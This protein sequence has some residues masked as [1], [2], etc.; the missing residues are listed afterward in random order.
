ME[1]VYHGKV[2]EIERRK[3]SHDTAMSFAAGGTGS[4]SGIDKSRPQAGSVIYDDEPRFPHEVF[5]HPERKEI[6]EAAGI[7]MKQLNNM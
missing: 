2:P 4:K 5:A 1:E 6:E 3:N 7:E